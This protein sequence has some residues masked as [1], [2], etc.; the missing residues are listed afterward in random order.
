MEDR[1]VLR[2]IG[3]RVSDAQIGIFGAYELAAARYEVLCGQEGETG[4]ADPEPLSA[5]I[6]PPAAIS[7][8]GRQL[9]DTNRRNLYDTL[10]NLTADAEAQENTRTIAAVAAGTEVAA[11]EVT[12][13]VAEG[14]AEREV[15]ET[16]E[17]DAENETLPESRLRPSRMAGHRGEP[18]AGS[19][20]EE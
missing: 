9:S 18:V 11:V 15:K 16:E 13:A 3:L 19:P 7:T 5:C 14:E 1:K 12:E 17:S 2:N 10:R 6:H 4:V 20:T 8:A